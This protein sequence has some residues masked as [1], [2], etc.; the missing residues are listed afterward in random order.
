MQNGCDHRC[1]FCV[2]PYGRGN[3]RSVPA[4]LV[5]ERIKRLVDAGMHEVV[6]TGVDLT[7]WGADLPGAPT[8]GSLVQR[9]LKFVPELKRLR[10]S[11][12]DAIETDPALVEAI[13][14]E[15]RVMPHLHLSLQAGDDMI[16]KRMKRRHTRA[17]AVEFVDDASR[18][19]A[20]RLRSAPTSSPA[21][22]PRPRRCSRTR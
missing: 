15:E 13:A 17:D 14:G 20:R 5:V 10:L 6:L 9:I 22:R 12:I 7:S 3:S 11:S 4:G 18:Q 8:L 16:L 21:S 2:I 1:T 19:G